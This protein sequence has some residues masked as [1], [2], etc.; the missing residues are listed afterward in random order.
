MRYKNF[1]II[2]AVIVCINIPAAKYST[3]QK[4]DVSFLSIKKI[5]T[6]DYIKNKMKYYHFGAL[7]LSEKNK[8]ILAKNNIKII[9]KNCVA[10]PELMYYNKIIMEKTHIKL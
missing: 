7:P 9:N 4:S 6:D 3:I 2:I 5:A 1:N 8:A 10:I